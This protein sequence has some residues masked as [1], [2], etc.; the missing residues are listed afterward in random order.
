MAKDSIKKRLAS[1]LRKEGEWKPKGMLT[2]TM[3]WFYYEK[4]IRK[5]YLAETIGRKLRELEEDGII[6]VKDDGVSVQY[7]Y[8]PQEIKSRYIRYSERTEK[9]ILLRPV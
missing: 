9:H 7:K 4:G 8:L 2:D 5:K 6:A 1:F 3:E